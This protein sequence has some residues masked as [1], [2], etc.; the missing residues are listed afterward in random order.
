MSDQVA[1]RVNRPGGMPAPVVTPVNEGMWRAAAVDQLAV[2][3]CLDCGAHRYP[4]GD[5]C[6]RCASLRWEW[7]R[8]P[9]TGV[10]YSYIWVP[11]RKRAAAGEG[12]CYNVAVVTLDGTEGEPV[13]VLSNVVNAWD[14]ADLRVGQVVEVVGVPFADGLALPCFRTVP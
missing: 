5:G 13:R 7:D 4:P 10:I 8:L 1:D 9:G 12:G 11:D 14:A 3:R 6:Y 2:Q